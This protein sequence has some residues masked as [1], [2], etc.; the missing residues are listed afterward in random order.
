MKNRLAILTFAIL[1]AV[2]TMSPAS[3]LA[4]ENDVDAVRAAADKFYV[5]LNTM[6]VGDLGPMINVWSHSSDVTFM[7]PDGGRR[8]GWDQVLADWESQAALKLGGEVR[9]ERMHITLEGNLAVVNN[10]EVGQNI[11]ADG[12]AEKVEIRAT[13]VFRKENGK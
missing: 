3:T 2:T 13:N 12:K 8:V 6:F 4:D 10:F 11:S 5:A 9:A 7:G 1:S